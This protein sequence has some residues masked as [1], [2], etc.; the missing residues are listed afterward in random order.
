[1]SQLSSGVHCSSDLNTR[2]SQTKPKIL[3]V[4]LIHITSSSLS[5]PQSDRNTTCSSKAAQIFQVSARASIYHP[6]ELAKLSFL[7]KQHLQSE[8]SLMSN[9]NMSIM[10]SNIMTI[11]RHL[12]A[13]HAESRQK[14]KS[15]KSPNGLLQTPWCRPDSQGCYHLQVL[16]P[17]LCLRQCPPRDRI[18]NPF[19]CFP[20]SGSCHTVS[21]KSQVKY[22]NT[23]NAQVLKIEQKTSTVLK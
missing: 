13:Q 1:M 16:I 7:K 14:V 5:M 15:T 23:F 9:S 18:F 19:T 20:I 4:W 8:T 17:L 10:R 21:Q 3:S 2:S 22:L 11:T 6:T 12:S